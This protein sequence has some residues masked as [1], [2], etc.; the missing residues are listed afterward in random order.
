MNEWRHF[1]NDLVISVVAE[2][3]RANTAAVRTL[4]TCHHPRRPSLL[5]AGIVW[6]S[7]HLGIK[8]VS[9]SLKSHHIAAKA[10]DL[11]PSA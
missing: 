7:P 8:I 6:D 4:D 3:R 11:V 2:I 10:H 9:I 1:R 5:S